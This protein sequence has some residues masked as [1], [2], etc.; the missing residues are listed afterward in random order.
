M[1]TR[2]KC[3]ACSGSLCSWGCRCAS[4]PRRTRT[5]SSSGSAHSQRCFL[6]RAPTQ[7]RHDATS[8]LSKSMNSKD[9]MRS[10]TSLL[11]QKWFKSLMFS[12]CMQVILT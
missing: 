11:P 4:T 2:S 10:A 12:A 9:E 3:S 1:S 8:H 5:L 6:G 7:P